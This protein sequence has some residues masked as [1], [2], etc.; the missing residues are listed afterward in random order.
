MVVRVKGKGITSTGF[1]TGHS[2]RR[3]I[4]IL[5]LHYNIKSTKQR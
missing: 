4:N 5:L 1:V 3:I 2:S